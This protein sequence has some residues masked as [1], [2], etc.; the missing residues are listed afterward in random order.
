[1]TTDKD[2][3]IRRLKRQVKQLRDALQP[4]SN[5]ESN[6]TNYKGSDAVFVRGCVYVHDV[7]KAAE[8][9]RKTE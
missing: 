7:R 5:L 6:Y 1:M 8:V 4:L 2:K 3:E 9:M